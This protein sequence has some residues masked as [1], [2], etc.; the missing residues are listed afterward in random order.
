MSSVSSKYL[1]VEA[2]QILV[3]LV[4]PVRIW[5]PQSI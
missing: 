3:N 2:T 5:E 1:V 4:N